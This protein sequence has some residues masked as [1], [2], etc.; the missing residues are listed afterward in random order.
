M[1]LLDED[2]KGPET[3][4]PTSGNTLSSS[5]FE[6]GATPPPRPLHAPSSWKPARILAHRFETL[7]RNRAGRFTRCAV[8]FGERAIGNGRAPRREPA[9]TSS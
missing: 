9:S 3:H 8:G 1:A 6:V 2:E 4:L 5:I 7:Q